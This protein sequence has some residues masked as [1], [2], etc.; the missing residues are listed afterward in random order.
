M[1]RL[2]YDVSTW[3][4]NR[5]LAT[6]GLLLSF[7]L[8]GLAL[9]DLSR[10]SSPESYRMDTWIVS[11]ETL[12]AYTLKGHFHWQPQVFTFFMVHFAIVH[13][14]YSGFLMIFYTE[15]LERG[16]SSKFMLATFFFT[17]VLAPIALSPLL[18]WVIKPAVDPLPFGILQQTYF[19]GSSV[20]IW[21]TIGMTVSISRKRRLYWVPIF[22]LLFLEFF[23]K[24]AFLAEA[25]I[26]A[27][28]VHL[29]VFLAT[30][31][32]SR[33]FVQFKNNDMKV[34]EINLKSKD[35]WITF[36][37]LTFHALIMTIHFLDT[38]GMFPKN[39]LAYLFP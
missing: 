22:I 25:D 30:Y 21:G 32:F 8:L 17:A 4:S 13:Y 16:T 7:Y 23:L 5:P 15:G 39:V 33:T 2:V 18:F 19:L 36:S 24:L 6:Y 27:N 26:T 38:L 10:V 14:G 1:K 31:A 3:K 34:G 29:I 11:L 12:E 28:V 37:L 20:G 35:G 9:L